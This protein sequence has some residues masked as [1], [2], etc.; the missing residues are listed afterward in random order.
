[1]I[2]NYLRALIC[3]FVLCSGVVSAQMPSQMSISEDGRR[4]TLGGKASEGLYEETQVRTID[5]QFENDN[6]WAE[7]TAGGGGGPF[8]SEPNPDVLATVTVEGESYDSVGIRIKGATSDFQNDSEKKS[9]NVTVDYAIGGQ[10]IMGYETLNLNG[11]YL[12]RS[13]VREVLYNYI[14]RQYNPS[15]QANFVEVYLNGQN[16]GPYTNVQQLN[17]EFL[18]E[19]FWN[20]NGTRWRALKT[21]EGGPGSPGGPFGTGISG[22]NYLG[23][24][25]EAYEDAYTL[26]NT[27]KEEPWEDLIRV[28]DKLNNLPL[29]QLADS[30]RQYMDVDKALWFLAH[31]IIFADDDSYVHKGGMDYYLYWDKETNLMIPLEYDGNTVMQEDGWSPFYNENDTDYPLMNRLFAVPELRQR[32]LAHMRTILNTYMIP[33]QLN[34]KID[35][36]TALIDDLVQNDPKAIYTYNQYLNNVE[37]V[38]DFI[39]E[40][41]D[42]LLNAPEVNVEGL[43]ISGVVHIANGEELGSV[44]PEDEVTITAN[45][46]GAMGVD[47]VVLYYGSGFVGVFS[48]TEMYDDGAHNDGAANDGVYGANVPAFEAASYVRY[49]VEAIA[50]NATKTATYMPQRAEQDVY[51][52]QVEIQEA[53]ERPIVINELMASNNTS[54][55]D[56]VGDFDDWIELYNVSDTPVDLSGYFI[57]DNINN[58]RKFEFA[59]GT[60]LNPGEYLIV[61]ADENGSQGDLHANFKL[62]SSGESVLL[63]NPDIE[64]MDRVDFTELESDKGYARVPNGTGD[65]VLQNHTFAANNSPISSLSET[66][67]T[68]IELYPNPTNTYITIDLGTNEKQYVS[69]MN[70]QGGVIWEKNISKQTQVDVSEWAAGVYYIK[71]ERGVKRFIV[72]P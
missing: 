53:A 11:G 31:E 41:R 58:L 50:N 21:T 25:T 9:F 34:A 48:E 33:N 10:D 4:L 56:E 40:R 61:W 13:A 18:K 44:L 28:C 45:V 49:Y 30:L 37:G 23:D 71:M 16:W 6:F 8:G 38:R 51:I 22:L 64:W 65:F 17:G 47:K 54:V 5:I 66:N 35:D 67:L 20:N 55:A 70:V 52:Y 72:L 39:E 60:I 14:G 62:S 7:L 43:D 27:Q 42:F 59:E 69:I 57:T 63:L 29:D 36:Y 15:L 1:M 26:K 46:S 68:Q 24:D 32:Y 3:L 2:K 19:W 12:D